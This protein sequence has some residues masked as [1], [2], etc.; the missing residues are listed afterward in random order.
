MVSTRRTPAKPDPPVLGHSEEV[1]RSSNMKEP[2]LQAQ[3]EEVCVP[4]MWSKLYTAFVEGLRTPLLQSMQCCISRHCSS[5]ARAE[6]GQGCHRPPAHMLTAATKAAGSNAQ[7]VFEMQRKWRKPRSLLGRLRLFLRTM[8]FRT[9]YILGAYFFD[10]WETAIVYS[11]YFV[12]L[13][14][15]CLGACKQ[16]HNLYILAWD[17]YNARWGS[18]AAIQ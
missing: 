9:D 11:M 18:G 16:L 14:V 7:L 3:Q 4:A 17:F 6:G 10:W 5:C 15:A 13:V 1:N 8:L 2:S 12:L